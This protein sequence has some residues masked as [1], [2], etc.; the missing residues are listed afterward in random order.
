MSVFVRSWKIPIKTVTAPL[1][2][3]LIVQ[4]SFAAFPQYC[5]VAIIE[6]LSILIGTKKDKFTIKECTGKSRLL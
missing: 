5:D 4:E 1:P 6:I 3:N 2:T